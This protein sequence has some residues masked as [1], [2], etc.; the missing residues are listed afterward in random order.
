MVDGTSKYGIGLV[1]IFDYRERNSNENPLI[2]R[3]IGRADM[4]EGMQKYLLGIRETQDVTIEGIGEDA[5]IHGFGITFKNAKNIELCNFAIM[6]YGG[7]TD[8]DATALDGN[9]DNI[10]IHNIEY[11]YGAH[12]TNGK[13]NFVLKFYSKLH[14]DKGKKRAY[15]KIIKSLLK[16][17]FTGVKLWK[18]HIEGCLYLPL[19]H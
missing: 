3:I 16:N 4:P 11:F 18:K 1:G 14:I 19:L 2:V 13:L 7:G 8:S 17:C 9:N 12:G 5:A 10:W 6:W 15:N